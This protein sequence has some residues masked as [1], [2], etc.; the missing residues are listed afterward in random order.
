MVFA[1]IASALGSRGSRRAG[2]R[3]EVPFGSGHV[4]AP[5]HRHSKAISTANQRQSALH[6]T[7][8]TRTHAAHTTAA[9]GAYEPYA[10][11][12]PAARALRSGAVVSRVPREHAASEAASRT[13]GMARAGEPIATA[14]CSGSRIYVACLVV[15]ALVAGDRLADAHAVQP[16]RAPRRR[17]APRSPGPARRRA[18]LRREQR[19]RRLRGQDVHQLPAL[20]GDA[21]AAARLAR[22]QPRELPR[23]AVH[24]V[25][26]R[27]RAG[28]A[29]PR[30]REDAAHGALR[31]HR[32]REPPARAALRV[33]HRL[34]LHRRPGHGLV[35]RARRRASG[36]RR[37]SCSSRSTPSAR[38][39]PG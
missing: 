8:W 31:A 11:R 9:F 33:R 15:F 6:A 21:D 23:R 28:G 26:R 7:M 27:H 39:S 19:L 36:S 10:A 12:G 35:R 17:V 24:R 13:R 32:G 1:R 18:R 30:A 34:L 38:S 29:L 5:C 4:Q 37:S 3:R 2:C 25:A 14:S 16:L 20:P 22:G